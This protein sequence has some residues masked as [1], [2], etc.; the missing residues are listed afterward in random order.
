[1]SACR[2]GLLLVWLAPTPI[3]AQQD[4]PGQIDFA[5]GL[6]C[7][8]NL[9][10][11]CALS[12]LQKALRAFSPESDPQ[13]LQHVRS[14]HWTLTLIHVAADDLYLA[15]KELMTLMLSDPAF[16]LPPGDHPPKVRY[17]Y[18]QVQ[19]KLGQ[20]PPRQKPPPKKSAAPVPVPPAS[21]DHTAPARYTMR[22]A[23]MIRAIVLFGDDAQSIKPGPGVGLRFGLLALRNL[24]ADVS[25]S[26][27]YH[28]LQR[29]EGKL[30]SFTLTGAGHFEYQLP[31]VSLRVGLGMGVMSMGT[32]DRYD[33]WGFH[34]QLSGQ[35]A[36]PESKFW[37]IVLGLNPSFVFTHDASSFY[38]PID[39]ALEFRW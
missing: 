31:I 4:Y 8:Q 17:I 12:R 16:V 39:L 23:P 35:L 18:Q 28:S 5:A 24:W 30:Q 6:V 38:L 2:L 29:D 19:T 26:Y 20:T 33:N 25:L 36:W 27:S 14:A 21:I 22:L 10:M 15:E 1:M 11:A 32:Q 37:A 3:S 7:Y 34:L 9:D 13:Y